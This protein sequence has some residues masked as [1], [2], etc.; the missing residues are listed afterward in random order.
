MAAA[1]AAVGWWL[2]LAPPE[3]ALV[4]TAMAL[5]G[6]A[7][8]INTALEKLADTVHPARHPGIG[9]AKDIAAGAV[10]LAIL[11]ALGIGLAVLGPRLLAKL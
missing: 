6:M 10:L 4:L 2:K 11:F 7:E 3:W 1:T 9:Q 8:A 5:V